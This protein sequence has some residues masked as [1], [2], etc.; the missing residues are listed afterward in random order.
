MSPSI[1]RTAGIVFVLIAVIAG[2]LK[3]TDAHERDFPTIVFVC[4]MLIIGVVLI[5]RS[6]GTVR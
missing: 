1:N 3:L 5:V 6:K 4:S 2:L